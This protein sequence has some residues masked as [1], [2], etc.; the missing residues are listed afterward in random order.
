MF[1]H[2]A[3]HRT[4]VAAVSARL[5]GLALT[6]AALGLAPTAQAADPGRVLLLHVD[7]KNP[8]VERDGLFEAMRN[9]LASY[10]NVEIVKAPDGDITDQMIELEC[11]DLDDECLGKLATQAKAQ[12]VIHAEAGKRGRLTTLKLRIVDAAG[13]SEAEQTLEARDANALAPLAAA[14]IEAALGPPPPV[15]V[16]G[17]LMVE[18]SSPSASI[19]LGAELIGTGTTTVSLDPGEYTIRVTHAGSE[20]VIRKVKV[21]ADDTTVERVTLVPLPVAKPPEDK[22][23]DDEAGAAWLPWVLVGAAVVGGTVAAILLLSG[24]E[25]STVRGPAVLGIDPNSAWRDPLTNGGRR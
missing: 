14:A 3:P 15:V 7:G 22:K 18:V 25:D 5:L 1:R 23:P 16:K 12:R 9:K 21:A 4:R 6:L 13:K 10:S 2:A 19:Y 17:R 20:E 8:E 11:I 24:D